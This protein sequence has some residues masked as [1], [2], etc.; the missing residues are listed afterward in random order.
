MLQLC[1]Y[2]T[3]QASDIVYVRVMITA[4]EWT[5]HKLACRVKSMS[6]AALA[7]RMTKI[8]NKAKMESL[9]QVSKKWQ[10]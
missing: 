8:Q 3:V 7:R 9:I 10:V 2:Q 4:G 5:T 1:Q 6:A